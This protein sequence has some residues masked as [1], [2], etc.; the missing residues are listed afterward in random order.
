MDGERLLCQVC[1]MTITPLP[2]RCSASFERHLRAQNRSERTVGNY[3]ESATLAEG[4]WRAAADAEPFD[5]A[6]AD[7]ELVRLD[8]SDPMASEVGTGRPSGRGS[9]TM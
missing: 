9:S 5:H 3:L 6:V 4:F 2:A 1:G 8:A 7:V